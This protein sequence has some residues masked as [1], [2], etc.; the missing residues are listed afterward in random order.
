MKGFKMKKET[1]IGRI[2]RELNEMGMNRNAATQYLVSQS[3]PFATH[4]CKIML[5]GSQSEEWLKDWS[6]EVFNYCTNVAGT[7]LPKGKRLK[8]KDYLEFFFLA[9]LGS[10]NELQRKLRN[11]EKTFIQKEN[12]P[13]SELVIT[14]YLYR[15]YLKFVDSI[16][17]DVVDDNIDYRD[18]IEKCRVLVGE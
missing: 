9:P 8:E 13:K 14:D 10:F 17:D 18:F 5:W 11:I 1:I 7:D 3:V 4:I 16:I 2:L 12:Y 15:I 6:D